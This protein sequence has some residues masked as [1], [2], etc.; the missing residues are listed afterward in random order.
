MKSLESEA[1]ESKFESPPKVE[2]TKRVMFKFTNGE[3]VSSVVCKEGEYFTP[4]DLKMLQRLLKLSWREYQ[5]N[6][7]LENRQKVRKDVG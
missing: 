7:L 6:Q 1:R 5:R 2:W 3:W 4:R